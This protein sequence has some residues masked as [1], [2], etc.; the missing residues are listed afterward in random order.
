MIGLVIF[1]HT[2]IFNKVPGDSDAEL[3]IR[4]TQFLVVSLA[5][6]GGAISPSHERES[7]PYTVWMASD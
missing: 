4:S 1:L 5:L 3:D 2:F 6:N 7:M